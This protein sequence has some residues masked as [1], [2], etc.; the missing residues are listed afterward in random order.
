MQLLEKHAISHEQKQRFA[1]LASLDPTGLKS[2][3]VQGVPL[4]H[5]F[6][7]DESIETF[8]MVLHAGITHFPNNLGFLFNKHDGMTACEATMAKYGKDNAL[9]CIKNC[10]PSD[11]LF[12]S[13][14]LSKTEL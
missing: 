12:I 8:K 2:I 13:K 5:K 7:N 9:A 3:K 4:I 6:I 10:I 1:F 14:I 11:A